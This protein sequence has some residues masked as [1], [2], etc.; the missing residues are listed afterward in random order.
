METERWPVTT[1]YRHRKEGKEWYSLVEGGKLSGGY[2][3]K[4]DWKVTDQRHE[5]RLK[6]WILQRFKMCYK[7]FKAFLLTWWKLANWKSPLFEI[8]LYIRG[9]VI[10]SS[11]FV[12]YHCCNVTFFLYCLKIFVSKKKKK[13]TNFKIYS[14]LIS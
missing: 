2:K 6:R 4:R 13:W 3:V 1:G 14:Y 8:L 11:S 7:V 9:G 12:L 5:T 10:V